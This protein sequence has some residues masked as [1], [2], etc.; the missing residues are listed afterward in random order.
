MKKKILS[1]GGIDKGWKDSVGGERKY[2]TRVSK[3][4]ENRGSKKL[5]VCSLLSISGIVEDPAAYGKDHD[6][7]IYKKK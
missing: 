6:K 4:I 3:K 2:K 7:W 1:L 5:K